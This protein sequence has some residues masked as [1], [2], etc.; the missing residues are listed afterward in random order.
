MTTKSLRGKVAVVTGASGGIGLEFCKT[1]AERGATLLMVSND[2]GPLHKAAAII[3]DVYGVPAYPMTLDLC[4]PAATDRI[5]SYLGNL[6]LDPYILINNAGIFSF[7]PVTEIPDRKLETFVDLHVRAAT[8]LSTRFASYFRR[9]GSGYILN[10]SSMSCWMP[11]PGL[12]MYAATKAYIRVFT[13]ALHYEMR[14]YGVNV[15]VA[16]PGGIATDLFGL[17]DNLK[18]LALR[19]HAIQRPDVFAR[20]AVDRLMRGRKQYINGFINRMA[21]FFIGIMP[22]S[23]RMLV[24]HRLL[25]RGITKP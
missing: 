3:N 18:K 8:M 10:M 5:W 24:K 6:S 17:P 15:M 21:I 11:M 20:R 13:R 23:A 16:C 9:R 25:D 19:L 14:D 7:A 22:T 4:D 12:A 1:L 2:D